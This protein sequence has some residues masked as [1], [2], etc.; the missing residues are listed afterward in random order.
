MCVKSFTKFF[1]ARATLLPS[2]S[3]TVVISSVVVIR[4]GVGGGHRDKGH[5][6]GGMD[7]DYISLLD[8]HD[9]GTSW[10]PS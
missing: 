2:T 10:V 7:V 5:R 4:Y 3:G 9:T 8:T 1:T 6:G